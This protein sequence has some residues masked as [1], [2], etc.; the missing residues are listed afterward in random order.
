[1]SGYFS[2][3]VAVMWMGRLWM[4][5]LSSW[6]FFCAVL[7]G[8]DSRP[9]REESAAEAGRWEWSSEGTAKAPEA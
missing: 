5:C 6:S 8:P 9:A 7:I 4:M 3:N 2:G 1:M